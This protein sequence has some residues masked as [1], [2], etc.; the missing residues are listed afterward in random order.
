MVEC[1]LED[2]GRRISNEE[3]QQIKTFKIRAKSS[4][5]LSKHSDFEEFQSNYENEVV[6]DDMSIE[7]F[8]VIHN[9]ELMKGDNKIIEK[10]KIKLGSNIISR[11]SCANHKSN[12]AVRTATLKHPI[13]WKNLQALNK[14]SGHARNT[15]LINSIYKAADCR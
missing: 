4:D 10:L 9:Y 14:F 2:R 7:E 1:K 13:V 12:L 3:F 15:T 8:D 6:F 11:I 5:I